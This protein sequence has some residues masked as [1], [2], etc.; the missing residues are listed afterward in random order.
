MKIITVVFALGC[1][2][3]PLPA[4]DQ[5]PEGRL[6]FVSTRSG[7]ADIWTSGTDGGG[8]VNLTPVPGSELWTAWSPDGQRIAF[9][10]GAGF[11]RELWVMNA[12]GSAPVRVTTN[13]GAENAPEWSPDGTRIAVARF[14]PDFTFDLFVVTVDGSSADLRLTHDAD[15]DSFPTWSPDGEWIAFTS[16]REG[17]DAVW[18]IRADG[19]GAPE[20][21]TAAEM[22][23]GAPE[24]SHDGKSIAFVDIV[25]AT[26]EERDIWTLKLS[27]GK[28]AQV[29][30]TAENELLPDWS[31][32]DKWLVYER[33][34]IVDGELLLPDIFVTSVKHGGARN[35]TNSPGVL[36]FQPTWRPMEDRP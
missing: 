23:A 31:P 36:D 28:L 2:A 6:A 18:R 35:L 13:D 33:S 9:T 26:C 30:D 19:S 15:F 10:R 7:S 3:A 17:G 34:D 25:C 20:R 5:A 1:L 11:A 27:N 8:A 12:D 16:D 22:H 24:Y 32:D 14:A 4:D 21:Q 29:T